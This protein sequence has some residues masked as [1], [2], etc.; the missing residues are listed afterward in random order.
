MMLS[1]FKTKQTNPGYYNLLILLR[2]R[3]AKVYSIPWLCLVSP[4][5]LKQHRESQEFSWFR[6]C[7]GKLSKLSQS[8]EMHSLCHLD[9]YTF[10][11]N[12]KMVVQRRMTQTEWL[13]SSTERL[14]HSLPDK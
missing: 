7:W 8:T 9:K 4:D 2:L 3:A 11:P 13:D 1:K 10:V 5:L 14:G 6:N 12:Q